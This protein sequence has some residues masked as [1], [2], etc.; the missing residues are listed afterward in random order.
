MRQRRQESLAHAWGM[1]FSDVH[2]QSPSRDWTIY[3]SAWKATRL[4]VLATVEGY[5]EHSACL[6]KA[7]WLLVNAHVAV[8]SPKQTTLLLSNQPHPSDQ[9]IRNIEFTFYSWVGN[10]EKV[11]CSLLIKSW[12]FHSTM[13]G[14]YLFKTIQTLFGDLT[15]ASAKQYSLPP[16][17]LPSDGEGICC[18]GL[19]HQKHNLHRSMVKKT[20]TGWNID[21]QEVVMAYSST[22]SLR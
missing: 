9:S 17:Y 1:N 15:Y 18:C 4:S 22:V 14:D 10:R 20:G 12:P 3:K 19:E 8:K 13:V 2:M 6:T 21:K 5:Y 11:E 7:P 16:R